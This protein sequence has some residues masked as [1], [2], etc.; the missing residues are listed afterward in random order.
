MA[1]DFRARLRTRQYQSMSPL[2][3]RQ[4][5]GH[6]IPS[7]MR[8]TTTTDLRSIFVGNLPAS[9]NEE[10]LFHMFEPY[11]PIQHIEIVRKPSANRKQAIS[12]LKVGRS[13]TSD[14]CWNQY[15]RLH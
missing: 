10:E 1:D 4:S 7:P 13:L 12:A 9:I 3:A 8:R 15:L 11:G 5:H 6:V 14:S 2:R